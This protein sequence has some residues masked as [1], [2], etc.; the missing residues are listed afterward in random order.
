MLS[1]IPAGIF[2]RLRIFLGRLKPHALPVARRHI[3]LGSI[4]AGT[5][6]AVTSMFSHWLL[7]EVNLWFIAPMGAS[8]VLLFGVPSSPLAQ[9][10]SIVGGNVLSALIGVTVG[11]LVPDA[12]L[13]CGLAAALAIAGMYFLRCLHPPGG[14]VA[15]TAILGGAGVHSEGYS[16]AVPL[17][18]SVTREDIHAALLEG[19]FLDI[20]EDDVQELLENIEQQA[21]QRIATAARR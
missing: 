14:A 13:A 19:Q 1:V 7:G 6:L 12:A 9:P 20:D 8:A 17:G 5:G 16:R 11:M 3:V 2:S 18:I 15:L 4:G 10:W 21:R